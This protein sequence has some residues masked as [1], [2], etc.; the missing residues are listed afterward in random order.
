MTQD[1]D[2]QKAETFVTMADIIVLERRAQFAIT[3]DLLPFGTDDSFTFVDISCGEGFLSKTILEKYPN[4][5]GHAT[6]VAEEMITK[7]E[8]LLGAY[9]D[10]VSV[11]RH[12]IHDSDYLSK[13][14]SGPVGVITSSLAIHHCDDDEKAALYKAA[15]DKLT[16]PGA[17]IIID[18]TRPASD[19]GVQVNKKYWQSYMEQQSQQL[20]GSDAE[21]EKF[22]NIPVMFYEEPVE[23]DQPATLVDNLRMFADAGFRDVDCFWKKCGFTIFGGYK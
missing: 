8:S 14:V 9:G 5:V 6:D 23:E 18:V 13:V 16:T 4:S 15:F 22:K 21:Y 19:H 7:A 11:S 10:R 2:K 17:M 1:W 20:T 3:A 12:N